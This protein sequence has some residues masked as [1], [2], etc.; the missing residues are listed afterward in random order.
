MGLFHDI[1]E[2]F[3]INILRE[4][5]RIF[6]TFSDRGGVEV[7]RVRGDPRNAVRNMFLVSCLI[8]RL[9]D[10]AI[11]NAFLETLTIRSRHSRE[12]FYRV[13][14]ELSRNGIITTRGGTRSQRIILTPKG[15]RLASRLLTG[16]ENDNTR[17]EDIRES[18]RKHLWVFWIPMTR[19][20]DDDRDNL[21][22]SL[23]I[24]YS[25]SQGNGPEE[26]YRNIL[27]NIRRDLRRQNSVDS[28]YQVL[29]NRLVRLYS[30]STR[31]REEEPQEERERR[32]EER[33]ELPEQLQL[34]TD[35]IN[36]LHRYL[37]DVCMRVFIACVLR[38]RKRLTYFIYLAIASVIRMPRYIYLPHITFL[39][40][41]QMLGLFYPTI[42]QMFSTILLW[43]IGGILTHVVLGLVLAYVIAKIDKK[44]I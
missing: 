30:T 21:L 18:A 7:R 37:E 5:R 27:L 44:T 43:Y 3:R 32:R 39:A 31:V 28:L 12:V 24:L 34:I 2:L 16:E 17:W 29:V 14:E 36:V 15:L 4:L 11:T 1:V 25:H 10:L 33:E 26:F 20:R 13:K 38:F 22:R 6:G 9:F 8:G 23:L 40:V 19:L 41:I 42:Y 35:F